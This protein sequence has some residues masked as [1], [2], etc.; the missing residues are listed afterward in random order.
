M[1]V[2]LVLN[3]LEFLHFIID[4]YGTCILFQMMLLHMTYETEAVTNCITCFHL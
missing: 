3:F 4:G 1:E 2:R